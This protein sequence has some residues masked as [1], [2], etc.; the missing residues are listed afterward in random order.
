[1]NIGG[2]AGILVDPLGEGAGMNKTV[3]LFPCGVYIGK[4]QLCR[5]WQRI[6]K[7]RPELKGSGV[8]VGLKNAEET[9]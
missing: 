4:L 3:I 2:I 7:N 9:P 1:L 6:G 8:G 5:P